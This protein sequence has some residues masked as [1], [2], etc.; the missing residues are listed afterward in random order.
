[1]SDSASNHLC[2]SREQ[3]DFFLKSLREILQSDQFN[4]ETDLDILPKKKSEDSTDPY[5]TR[6]TMLDLDYNKEDVSRELLTLEVGNY[7]ETVLDDQGSDR[8]PFYAFIRSIQ[9]RDVYIKVKIRDFSRR[10]VFCVSFHY[11]RYPVPN[12]PYASIRI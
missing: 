8:P 1:M 2:Q 12:L 4:L 9:N 11:A 10:T 6:N 7:Y 5:T 3:V